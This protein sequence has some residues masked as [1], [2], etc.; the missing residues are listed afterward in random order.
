[1]SDSRTFSRSISFNKCNLLRT[2]CE[3]IFFQD[4]AGDVSQHKDAEKG[5]AVTAPKNTIKKKTQ[6]QCK[7][8]QS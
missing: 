3:Y 6:K 4:P 1:M 2:N 5:T 7:R 8:G